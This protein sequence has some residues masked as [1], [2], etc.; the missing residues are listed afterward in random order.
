M[1]NLLVLTI[2]I[3]G[4]LPGFMH[5]EKPAME[6]V[7]LGSGGPRAFGRAGSSFII[8]LDGQPRILMDVGPGAFLR[9][10]PGHRS[11]LQAIRILADWQVLNPFRLQ[12][13][14]TPEL[15]ILVL[16][17][18]HVKIWRRRHTIVGPDL[19]TKAQEKHV[20]FGLRLRLL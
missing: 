16:T 19:N 4:L 17:F 8:I 9:P 12:S 20:T 5:A 1:K 7:V 13:S 3:L 11:V 18:V 15:A 6:V 2:A 10:T 14:L